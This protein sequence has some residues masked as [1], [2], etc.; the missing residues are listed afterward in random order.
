MIAQ[1]T[2]GMESLK[3]SVLKG[4]V[5]V[6]KYSSDFCFLSLKPM[7]KTGCPD[8][9]STKDSSKVF[10]PFVCECVYLCGNLLKLFEWFTM[11]D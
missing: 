8:K 1:Q 9:V 7:M 3:M 10:L 6:G 2:H 4:Y 5:S 11:N